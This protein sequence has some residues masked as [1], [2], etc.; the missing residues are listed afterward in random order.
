[1]NSNNDY[2]ILDL[3][4]NEIKIKRK[5]SLDHELISKKLSGGVGFQKILEEIEIKSKDD[6]KDHD[7]N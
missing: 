2:K 5:G 6:L 1:L 3:Y 7:A 4:K